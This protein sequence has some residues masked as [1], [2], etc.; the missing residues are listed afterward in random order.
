VIS[1]GEQE[2]TPLHQWLD[3]APRSWRAI[4]EVFVDIGR[5][6]ASE[7]S[8]GSAHQEI[9]I[10]N[11]LIGRDGRAHL[12]DLKPAIKNL[13][14]VGPS[15]LRTAA[16]SLDER[17]AQM[18]STE[19]AAYLAP[20][21][22]KGWVADARSNQ[23][24][25]CVALY[26]A[27]YRQSPFDPEWAVSQAGAATSR[28][29]PLGSISFDLVVRSLNRTSL[30]NLAREVLGGNL[31][32]PPY[33]ADVPEWLERVVR[34]GLQSDPDERYGSMDDLLK[35]VTAELGGTPR[36]LGSSNQRSVGQWVLV[37]GIVLAVAALAV[38][39]KVAGWGR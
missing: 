6:L 26:R 15:G 19:A 29:T 20:E 35:D 37:V 22:F 1:V 25:F 32:A 4:T 11:V 18:Q 27:L 36:G 8:K 2:G 5:T 39:A 34:R 13:P 14:T 30:I 24:S 3:D 10:D 33:D 28:R 16:V 31:R 17:L 23:F 21:Q 9:R 12:H 7:H 38:V